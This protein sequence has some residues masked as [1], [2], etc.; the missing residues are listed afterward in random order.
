MSVLFLLFGIV[1]FTYYFS[2]AINKKELPCNCDNPET[3][4]IENA[5]N[6]KPSEIFNKMFTKPSVWQGYDAANVLR[7]DVDVINI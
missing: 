7:T 6:V 2:K 5:Y 1:L 4:E 3:N